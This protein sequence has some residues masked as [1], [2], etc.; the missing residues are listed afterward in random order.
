MSVKN[1]VALVINT[2][3]KAIQRIRPG[4]ILHADQGAGYCSSSYHDLLKEY[5]MVGSMS[6]K[7]TPYDNAPM[8]SFF[9]ILKNEGLK[10]YR[11]LDMRELQE[12]VK[13]FIE[14]YNNERPQWG[15][16]KLTPAEYRSQFG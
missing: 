12:K 11:G 13:G 4:I 8:E 10:L 5:G 2:L 16:N 9:S 14:Y 7:G 1:D 3:K 6:R 15:L